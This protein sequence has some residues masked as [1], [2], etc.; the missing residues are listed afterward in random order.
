MPLRVLSLTLHYCEQ[1]LD[2]KYFP[3]LLSFQWVTCGLR[4]FCCGTSLGL[5][6]KNVFKLGLTH[7]KTLRDFIVD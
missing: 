5:L 4:N 7:H 6:S 1:D 3:L 2:P